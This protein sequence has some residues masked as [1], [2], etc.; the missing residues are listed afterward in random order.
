MMHKY[1]SVMQPLYL[2]DATILYLYVYDL[3][4]VAFFKCQ[5]TITITMMLQ[6]YLNDATIV[7]VMQYL[8]FHQCSNCQKRGGGVDQSHDICRR[9]EG[10][11]GG[12]PQKSQTG[13][14]FGWGRL[15]AKPESRTRSARIL[16]A[17]PEPRARS[18][19]ELRAKPESRA[20]P[21]I[22]RGEGSG[23]GAR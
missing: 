14:Y 18:A 17:K 7:S 3:L 21:E 1:I 11:R 4:D 6:L 13:Q 5:F 10:L 8:Y 22:N 19:R 23:E 15:R 16:R 20:Q 12:I 9:G 2:S